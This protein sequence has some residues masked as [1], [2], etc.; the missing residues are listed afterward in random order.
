MAWTPDGAT[1]ITSDDHGAIKLWNA[2]S[3]TEM[4]TLPG[5][6]SDRE[7]PTL[8]VSPDGRWLASGDGQPGSPDTTGDRTEELL[9]WDLRT[10]QLRF[11]WLAYDRRISHML[12][13]STNDELFTCGWDKSIRRWHIPDGR[14]IAEYAMSYSTPTGLVLMEFPPLLVAGDADGAIWRWSLKSGEKLPM[15]NQRD[16][17]MYGFA[18]TPS[19]FTLAMAFGPVNALDKTRTGRVRLLDA[20]TWD[21]KATFEVGPGAP[22]AVAF[23]PDGQHMVATDYGGNVYLW[24]G[25]HSSAVFELTI[26]SPPPVSGN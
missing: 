20:R 10:Q 13:N 25:P 9:L 23:A 16:G 17:R 15:I 2:E 1:L 14:Q 8:A 18:A 7:L 22:L 12:F 3:G 4:G 21:H 6:R 5:H 24:D 26:P 19:G 11:R